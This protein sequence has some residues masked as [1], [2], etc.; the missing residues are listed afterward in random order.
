MEGVVTVTPTSPESETYV[1]GQRIYE[2]TMLQHGAVVRFGR[3]HCFRFCDPEVE[4]PVSV[5]W[6][7]PQVDVVL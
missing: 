2:T 7:T 3:H 1:N 5:P 4:D 6:S